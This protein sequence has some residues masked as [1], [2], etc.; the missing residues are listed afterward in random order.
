MLK[1]LFLTTFVAMT[2]SGQVQAE[3]PASSNLF[4]YCD[5]EYVPSSG[6]FAHQTLRYSFSR[7]AYFDPTDTV[8][9]IIYVDEQ[10][11]A[12]AFLPYHRNFVYSGTTSTKSPIS[13]YLDRQSNQAT[14]SHAGYTIHGQCYD[15]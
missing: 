7:V 10:T 13:L 5:I 2:T 6:F 9:V 4:A 1:A 3:H 8:D 15:F 12:E 14:V 11:A